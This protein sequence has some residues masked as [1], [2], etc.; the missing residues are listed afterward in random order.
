MAKLIPA[1]ASVTGKMTGGERRFARRLESHL[2]DDYLCWYDV[3]VG[4]RRM[5]PDF[6]VLHPRRG[7]LVIE[8]KDWK[9][10]TIRKMAKL[11]VTLGRSARRIRSSRRG[12]TRLGCAGSSSPTP[13]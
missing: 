11:S 12:S 4:P 3:P 8:V 5:H 2:E 1:I 13:R 7:L 9:L 10:Y 6:L